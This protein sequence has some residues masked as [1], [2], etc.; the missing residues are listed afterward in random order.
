M[1]LLRH[2]RKLSF[3]ILPMAMI[4]G[5]TSMEP[6]RTETY[7]C[8]EGREFS[9]A[10]TSRDNIRIDI[11]EMS[12]LLRPESVTNTGTTY[13]CGVLTLWRDGQTARVTMDQAEELQNCRRL[14]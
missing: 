14:P 8:D 2:S 3:C 10:F 12:F 9:V 11:A 6:A 4:A 13:G 7:R 1:N 5:C